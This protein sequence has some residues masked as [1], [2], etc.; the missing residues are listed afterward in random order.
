MDKFGKDTL[1]GEMCFQTDEPRPTTVTITSESA[2]LY[3]LYKTVYNSIMDTT[4]NIA[5]ELR[6][7]LARDVVSEVRIFSKL[8]SANKQQVLDA[9]VPLVFPDRTYICRQG[10]IGKG[11]YV[12]TEGKCKVTKN[13]SPSGNIEKEVRILEAGDYFGEIALLTSSNK[14][15]ANVIACDSVSVMSLGRADF[16]VLLSSIEEDMMRQNMV[17]GI[18]DSHAAGAQQNNKLKQLTARRR[19][20]GVDLHNI[21]SAERV[22]SLLPRMGKF[23]TES[24]W[25]SMYSRFYRVLLLTPPEEIS[26]FGAYA[27]EIYK[28]IRSTSRLMSVNVVREICCR[29][30]E[31][32]FSKRIADMQ[33]TPM[34]TTTNINTQGSLS[35]NISRT[36]SVDDSFK[37][38]MK[39]KNKVIK[40]VNEGNNS[41]DDAS[42]LAGMFSCR[43]QLTAKLCDKWTDQQILDLSKKVKLERVGAMKKVFTFGELGNMIYLILRGAVRIYTQQQS[44]AI[45]KSESNGSVSGIGGGDES[46]VHHRK[47]YQEDLCAGEIFGETALEGINVRTFMVQA[48]TNCEF[49]VISCDDYLSVLNSGRA[50]GGGSKSTLQL[51]VDAKYNFLMKVPCFKNWE[52]FRL[53]RL[54]SAT[55]QLHL[56]KDKIVMEKGKSMSDIHFLMNGTIA[57]IS[58]ATEYLNHISTSSC[59]SNPVTSVITTMVPYD[60]FGESGALNAL[61]RLKYPVVE[62]CDAVT[63]SYVDILVLPKVQFFLLDDAMGTIHNIKKT[64][65]AKRQWRTDRYEQLEQEREKAMDAEEKRIKD[66]SKRMTIA[67]SGETV[68]NPEVLHENNPIQD[69]WNTVTNHLGVAVMEGNQVDEDDYVSLDSLIKSREEKKDKKRRDRL[70]RRSLC[71][72]Q[73]SIGMSL[74]ND[75]STIATNFNE[76]GYVNEMSNSCHS[77][78]MDSSINTGLN[79]NNNQIRSSP[80][81]VNPR[82]YRSSSSPDEKHLKNHVNSTKGDIKNALAKP[83]QYRSMALNTKLNDSLRDVHLVHDERKFILSLPPDIKNQLKERLPGAGG[84]SFEMNTKSNNYFKTSHDTNLKYSGLNVLNSSNMKKHTKSNVTQN[85]N[86]KQPIMVSKSNTSIPIV[87][88]YNK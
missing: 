72:D 79:S 56:A 28:D 10:K 65:V 77:A 82:R 52:P 74:D 47:I 59:S 33:Y 23:M 87:M 69:I 11:F 14:S 83:Q 13:V 26:K 70:T 6:G 80:I 20:T 9:M 15:T 2:T 45:K 1:V 85:D 57:L 61:L 63:S 42:F 60:Y 16:H 34:S 19:I 48:I 54:A 50:N 36:S 88:M 55:Y 24:M 64:F 17:K 41:V 39:T 78:G 18:V 30:M 3:T 43:N 31:T 86:A 40:G 12:I 62:C 73:G 71:G 25:G 7:K 38:R 84:T 21:R 58:N 37:F 5:K 22:E 51:S 8:T 53:Y 29:I 27:E 44:H 66:R 81:R 49:A 76:T 32:D 68:E 4:K 75:N 35:T 46:T 67:R